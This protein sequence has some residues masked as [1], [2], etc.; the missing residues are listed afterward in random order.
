MT[1]A[2]PSAPPAAVA[3]PDAPPGPAAKRRC[4][5]GRVLDS[6]RQFFNDEIYYSCRALVHPVTGETAALFLMS[7]VQ[8]RLAGHLADVVV[9]VAGAVARFR[10]G[11]VA[12]PL[13]GVDPEMR[14]FVLGLCL[15]DGSEPAV[16]YAWVLKQFR[17]V[18]FPKA[19]AV[20]SFVTDPADDVERAVAASFPSAAV[21]EPAAAVL[22]SAR[23]C[24]RPVGLDALAERLSAA[25]A[26]PAAADRFV[27]EARALAR[28]PAAAAAL[29]TVTR[30][31]LHTVTW[32]PA[33]TATVHDLLLE[34]V[35][36]RNAVAD[37]QTRLD[38]LAEAYQ[39]CN[40]LKYDVLDCRAVRE[41]P[42]PRRGAL[43]SFAAARV[44][45]GRADNVRLGLPAAGGGHAH[46]RWTT[47]VFDGL[48]PLASP[49][50]VAVG[51]TDRPADRKIHAPIP[52]LARPRPRRP[53]WGA[54]PP[55]A[56]KPNWP[57][58]R[59]SGA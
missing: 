33:Q 59:L 21:V 6:V 46:P 31:F 14:P 29:A 30:R 49:S 32:T 19:A 44:R 40:V 11:V 7:D 58:P 22:A 45:A 13:V 3:R 53:A 52:T 37:L 35:V 17:A 25:A 10:G 48:R 47:A 38:G 27:T 24:L 23:A 28:A 50:R 55:T 8:I 34:P 2:S 20:A 16:P 54:P 42:R 57:V 18:A 43:S 41:A 9:A 15:V 39:L 5:G 56:A 36:A 12:W 1:D 4:S 51:R 26:S